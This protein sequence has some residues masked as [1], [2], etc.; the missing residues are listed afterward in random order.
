[1]DTHFGEHRAHLLSRREGSYLW[2]GDVDN[3][4]LTSLHPIHYFPLIS[5]TNGYLTID[6]VITCGV[7]NIPLLVTLTHC[8]YTISSLIF[9]ISNFLRIYK[10][11][12]RTHTHTYTHAR[13]MKYA[14]NNSR[15][16]LC[17]IQRMPFREHYLICIYILCSPHKARMPRLRLPRSLYPPLKFLYKC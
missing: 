7:I 13:I 12:V 11:I 3:R 4:E 5:T 15:L 1:M 6:Y 14:N 10:I 9:A 17:R 16:N 8:T 2:R